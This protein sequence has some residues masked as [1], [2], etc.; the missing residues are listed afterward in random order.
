ME[1]KEYIKIRGKVIEAGF[2]GDID[3]SENLSPATMTVSELVCEYIWVVLNSGM[4]NTV[5]RKIETKV[6]DALEGGKCV[7][8]PDTSIFRHK[9]KCKAI[10]EAWDKREELFAEFA[11][12]KDDPDKVMEFIVSLPYTKGKILRWHFA[13]NVGLD[14]AKPDRHL[15]RIAAHYGTTPNDLCARLSRGSGDRVATVDMVLWRAA[16]QGIIRPNSTKGE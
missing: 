13:K 1:I 11:K 10:Q 4:K 8:P 14:V 12:A 5:A 16:E 15:V 9:L 2:Q 6:L 7:F 3:W